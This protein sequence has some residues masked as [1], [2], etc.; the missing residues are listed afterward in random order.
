MRCF[1]ALP[2]PDALV[3]ALEPLLEAMPVGYPLSP[4]NLHLTL[5]FLGEQPDFQLQAVHEALTDLRLPKFSLQLSGLGTFGEANP[6][7]VWA[8]LKEATAVNALQSKVM[9]A[10][11][12]AELTLPH[13]RFRPHVTLARLGRLGP[14]EDEKLARFLSKR[15]SFS[16][17]EVEIESFALYQ[18]LRTKAEPVYEILSDYPL[19]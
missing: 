7:T 10:L 15:H 8:G 16:C 11:H 6:H 5:A 12:R 13:R 4:E 2:L 1:I 3:D 18:S 17:P 9:G 14:G 19:I